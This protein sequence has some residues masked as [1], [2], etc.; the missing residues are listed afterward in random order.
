MLSTHTYTILHK[1]Y[2]SNGIL[3]NR[4]VLPLNTRMKLFIF[5]CTNWNWIF[6]SWIQQ[7]WNVN[8]SLCQSVCI[9]HQRW[10]NGG[11]RR[12][13]SARRMNQ[14]VVRLKRWV[15]GHQS[16]YQHNQ[17]TPFIQPAS[18]CSQLFGCAQVKKHRQSVVAFSQKPEWPFTLPGG[19]VSD[20]AFATELTF[21]SAN[22]KAYSRAHPATYTFQI[23]SLVSWRDQWIRIGNRREIEAANK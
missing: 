7:K 20:S 19:I 22:K 4:S 10:F 2:A 21:A 13:N 18:L 16:N 15:M 11:K 3:S 5:I 17:S 12:P 23:S 8:L 14:A 6:L 9:E 1:I